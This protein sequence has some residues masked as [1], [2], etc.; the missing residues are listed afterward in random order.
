MRFGVAT[1]ELQGSASTLRRDADDVGG[2]RGPLAAAGETTGG[3]SVGRAH[4]AA[5]AFFDAA[6]QAAGDAETGLRELGNRAAAAAGE[7][8]GVEGRLSVTP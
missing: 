3:W 1:E 6:A 2:L 8:D 4:R 5:Q 7:Y